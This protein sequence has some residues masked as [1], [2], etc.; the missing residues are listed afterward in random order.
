METNKAP[1]PGEVRVRPVGGVELRRGDDRFKGYQLDGCADAFS[2][3]LPPSRNLS[4]TG[5]IHY[6]AT[7]SA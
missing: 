5:D 1:R 6:A 4:V 7:V 2:R 3:Y